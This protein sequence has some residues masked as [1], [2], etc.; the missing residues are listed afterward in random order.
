MKVRK[1]IVNAKHVL[2]LQMDVWSSIDDNTIKRKTNIIS[3]P[4]SSITIGSSTYKLMS[5]VSL[6]L[7]TRPSGHYFAILSTK[8][9]K[10]LHFRIWLP[11]LPLGLVEEKTC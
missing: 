1:E 2:I 11:L 9:R 3:L 4:D 10:W 7:S 6:L 8:G 5:A